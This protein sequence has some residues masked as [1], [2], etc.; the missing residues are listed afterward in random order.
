MTWRTPEDGLGA[1]ARAETEQEHLCHLETST[2]CPPSTAPVLH[3]RVSTHLGLAVWRASWA[4]G[5]K[6]V[7]IGPFIPT[8][9]PRGGRGG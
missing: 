5:F 8:G 6:T 2:E 7:L 4:L 9:V 1:V 3:P